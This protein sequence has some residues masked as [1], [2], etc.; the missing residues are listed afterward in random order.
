MDP[1]QLRMLRGSHEIPPVA[2][3]E[4]VPANSVG[5]VAQSEDPGVPVGNLWDSES[6]PPALSSGFTRPVVLVDQ[7]TQDRSTCDA[8]MVEIRAGWVGR[9]G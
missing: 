5:V 3:G 4:P 1:Y 8:F 2:I 7:P 9:G 6:R